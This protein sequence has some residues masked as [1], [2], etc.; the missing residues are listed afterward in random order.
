MVQGVQQSQHHLLSA[1]QLLEGEQGD[2]S[3]PGLETNFIEAKGAILGV[4]D[5]AFIPAPRN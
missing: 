2:L 3:Q 1:F 5:T 4:A